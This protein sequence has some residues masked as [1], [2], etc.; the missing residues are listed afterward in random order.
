MIPLQEWIRG[1]GAIY[2]TWGYLLVFLGSLGENT[3]MLGLIL[4]GGTLA[5]LGAFYARLGTL[6]LGLVIV[7]AWMGTVLGYHC[8]Y[9][10]GRFVLGRVLP[11]WSKSRLGRRIRLAGRMRL[12][13]M[14]L[15]KHGGKAILISHLVG[16]L[17]SFIA[18]SAGL[19]RMSYPRF[20]LFELLAAL[21]WNTAYSLLGYFVAIE[22][23]TLLL[24]IERAGWGIAVAI[25]LIAGIWYIRKYMARKARRMRRMRR[26]R[27]RNTQQVTEM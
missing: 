9:L 19:T 13:R 25:A 27:Y 1:L 7:F 5:L 4:P 6:N 12:A 17:R 15:F 10:F 20:L 23:D 26:V 21:L 24:V 3:A 8:D 18:L 2:D 14:F 22:I 11:R 16:H